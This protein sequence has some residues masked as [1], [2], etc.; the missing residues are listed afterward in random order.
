MTYIWHIFDIYFAIVAYIL[1]LDHVRGLQS[2]AL[3]YDN[4]TGLRILT[5]SDYIF[6]RMFII[7]IVLS[8]WEK[9]FH[10]PFLFQLCLVVC[11]VF[12]SQT[13]VCGFDTQCAL[14]TCYRMTWIWMRCK[15]ERCVFRNVFWKFVW[16]KGLEI[17]PAF[18]FQVSQLLLHV[19]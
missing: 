13:K 4:V 15:R 3:V 19:H 6:H 2:V 10:R 17:Q 18:S 1:T 12:G 16:L 5:F 8:I 9:R 14:A 11:K 7:K